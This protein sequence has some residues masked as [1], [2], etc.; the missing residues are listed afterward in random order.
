[1][2]S[3]LEAINTILTTLA[4]LE[5]NE[6]K[7]VL[8]YV[9]KRLNI[10][11][12]QL[13]GGT[14]IQGEDMV[15]AANEAPDQEVIP[16][17]KSTDIKELKEIKKPKSAIQMAV[18]VAYYLQELAAKDDRKENVGV[19]DIKKYFKQAAYPQPQ[20]PSD[21]LKNA[22]NSGY[23][24]SVDR[25]Q[26]KL[27]SVGF[28]LAAYKMPEDSKRHTRKKTKPKKARKGKR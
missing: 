15:M 24:E 21:P 5:E 27:N 3:E 6:K 20:R 10:D 1:M 11:V 4:S 13:D 16:R 25:G 12:I 14:E 22:K 26:Y 19:E 23:L 8:E 9:S 2:D 17:E 7:R 28:N 18:L